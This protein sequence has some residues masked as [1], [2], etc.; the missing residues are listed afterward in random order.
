MCWR[1]LFSHA[2]ADNGALVGTFC[3]KAEKVI[4][5]G[6]FYFLPVAVLFLC[7]F[8]LIIFVCLGVCDAVGGRCGKMTVC[9]YWCV[10]HR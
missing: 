8:V 2:C 10:W 7:S 5:V 4:D 6:V 9:Y 3:A 1:D